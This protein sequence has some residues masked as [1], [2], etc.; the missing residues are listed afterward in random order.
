MGDGRCEAEGDGGKRVVEAK[1]RDG[2]I[3]AIQLVGEEQSR[4][5]GDGGVEGVCCPVGGCTRSQRFSK[6]VTP[7]LR[8]S[9]T[10]IAQPKGSI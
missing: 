9:R 8:D 1:D 5:V 3:R 2:D 10:R 7:M 4:A 6:M